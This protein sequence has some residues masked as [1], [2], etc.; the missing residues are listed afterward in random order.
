[1]TSI[2]QKK[3]RLTTVRFAGY[4]A[5][6][7]FTVRLN[8]MNVLVGANNSGKSTVLGAFRILDLGLR[9]MLSKKAG[10]I[11]GPNGKR[12]GWRIPEDSLPV[13]AE[14]VHTNYAEVD[15]TIRFSVSNGST[16]TIFFP[17]D[18]G[19]FIFADTEHGN[20]R[21]PQDV[22]R[23]IPI[24][25]T[26]VPILGPVEH[27][28]KIVLEETVR[29]N[30]STTRASR[31]FRNYWLYHREGFEGFA[32][33]VAKTWSGM[34]VHPPERVDDLVVM[35]CDERRYA[36]ELFWSGFGFQIWLQLLTHISRSGSSSMIVVDEPELYLH[37][38]VQRQLLGLLRESGADLLMATH[39]TEVMA[40]ADPTE[41][42]LIDK[43]KKNSER[44]R[45]TEGVQRALKIIGSIQNITLAKLARSRRV[46]FV[47]GDADARLIGRFA[48]KLGYG[49]VAAWTDITPLESGGFSSWQR[50][51]ALAA[52]FEEALGFK[53][54]VAAVFDRD[55]WCDEE[56]AVIQRELAQHLQVAHLHRRK[57][58]ESYLLVPQVLNRAID[59]AIRERNERVDDARSRSVSAEVYLQD[60][61]APMKSDIQAQCISKRLKFFE[62]SAA[63]PST[64]AKQGIEQFEMRWDKLDTRIQMV[65]GKAVLAALR[66]KV[67]EEYGITL[68]DHRIVSEFSAS[69]IPQ[70]LVALIEQLEVF[71]TS[72]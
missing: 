10:L 38:D 5:F 67:G 25:L 50:V 61:M 60:I 55:Y 3:A 59:A 49:Q 16:V 17:A 48:R 32:D 20:A 47:E 43:S 45:D 40:E 39:S 69:E 15:T 57:E 28:E 72:A 33:L 58:I 42:V 37:P 64:V 70:D 6:S 22:R 30:L 23:L 63:D 71:R 13:S 53:L 14:N 56:V 66:A 7:D 12:P 29:K 27:H 8:H 24:S 4:K 62:K 2:A 31:N 44:L 68:T 52:A 35:F 46:L 11:S 54:H 9:T 21:T 51:R 26:I 1:M 41:I 18:E 65:P 36:R 34:A 19:C